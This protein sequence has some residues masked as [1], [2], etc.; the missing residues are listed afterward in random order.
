M[1]GDVEISNHHRRVLFKKSKREKKN[2]NG[3]LLLSSFSRAESDIRLERKIWNPH[4][5]EAIKCDKGT[6]EHISADPSIACGLRRL[7]GLCKYC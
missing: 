5:L 2:S 4:A 1:V 3:S 6:D 7:G